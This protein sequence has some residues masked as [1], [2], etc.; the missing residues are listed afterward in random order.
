MTHKTKKRKHTLLLSI[1]ILLLVVAVALLLTLRSK[2]TSNTEPYTLYVPANS[3]YQAVTDTLRANGCLTSAATWHT[4]ARLRQYTHHV[5]GGRYVIKPHANLWLTLTKLYYGNQDPLQLTIGKQ[6]TP[7]TLCNYLGQKLELHPDS[8]LRLMQTDSIC[9]AY[10][11]TPQTIIGM[12]P[13]NTYQIYWNTT[14]R[15]F[16]DR[17]ATESKT[18]W[19]S[20]RQKQCQAL[21]LSQQEVLTLASIVDEETNANEEKADIASVYLNRLHKGMPL[22]ADPTVKYAVGDFTLRRILTVHTQTPSPYNTYLHA[23]LPPGP[24]CIPSAASIDAVLANKETPYL[25]FC[26]RAD[27]SGRH[28]FAATLAQHTANANAFHAELNRRKIYK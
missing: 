25:Y 20:A 9:A 23:G 6:R 4:L 12:F 5:K 14:P 8:L 22:Q 18:F 16:L 13:R 19:T 3:T 11:Y 27:F 21:G 28:A 26:A 17:M 1:P 2:K 24:I 7:Q 10:G 15:A